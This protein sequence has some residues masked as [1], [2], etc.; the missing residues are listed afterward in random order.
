MRKRIEQLLNGVFEYK[1]E[2]LILSEERISLFA[3]PDSRQ[4]SDFTISLASG[5]KV[6]GFLYSSN[7]RVSF[8]PQEFYGPLSKIRF[9]ADTSGLTHGE[10]IEGEFIL[11]TDRGEKSSL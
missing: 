7:P 9:E 4:G 11:C 2:P 5:K 3:A 8:A 10:K 6:K 1:E